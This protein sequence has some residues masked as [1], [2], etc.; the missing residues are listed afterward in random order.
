[1][2][3]RPIEPEFFALGLEPFGDSISPTVAG[4][5]DEEPDDLVLDLTEFEPLPKALVG[6]YLIG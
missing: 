5:A 1:L 2:E 4:P 3:H 6:S